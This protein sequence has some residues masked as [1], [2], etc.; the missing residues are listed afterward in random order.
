MTKTW[1]DAGAVLPL[2][3]AAA[4][5]AAEGALSSKRCSEIRAESLAP[6]EWMRSISR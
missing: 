2:L 1:R 3:A 5:A 4:P 6:P